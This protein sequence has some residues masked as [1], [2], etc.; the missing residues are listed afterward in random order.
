VKQLDDYYMHFTALSFFLF[1]KFYAYW[2]RHIKVTAN[3]K[4]GYFP[5]H[6]VYWYN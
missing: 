2:C 3:N 1:A 4:V 5:R 6:S